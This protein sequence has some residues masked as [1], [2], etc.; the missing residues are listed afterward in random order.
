MIIYTCRY[1]SSSS[2]AFWRN[3]LESQDARFGAVAR[4]R[5]RWRLVQVLVIPVLSPNGS[6]PFDRLER[7]DP[8]DSARPGCAPPLPPESPQGEFEQS[9]AGIER[10]DG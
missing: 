9:I 4:R 5:L 10:L 3:S 7:D 2:R 8:G 1:L 6:K